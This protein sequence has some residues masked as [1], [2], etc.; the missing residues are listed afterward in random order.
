M[1]AGWVF[2]SYR[3]SYRLTTKESKADFEMREI[4]SLKCIILCNLHSSSLNSGGKF[5]TSQCP[6]IQKFHL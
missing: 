3:V 1:P 5:V 2:S 4:S 6:G